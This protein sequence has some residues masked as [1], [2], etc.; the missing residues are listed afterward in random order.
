MPERR[1]TY[2]EPFLGGGALFF[3]Q[4]PASACISDINPHLI[5]TYKVVRD[6]V[7]LLITTLIAHSLR[8]SKEHYLEARR[9]LTLESDPVDLAAL[10]IYLNRTCFNGLYRVNRSGVFNVAFGSYKS[11]AIVQADRLRACSV[12]LQSVHI[13]HC[14]YWEVPLRAGNFYYLDPPYDNTFTG[15]AAAGFDQDEQVLLSEFCHQLD[16]AGCLFMAS[17]SDTPLIRSLYAGFHI[18]TVLARRSISCQR[19]QRG[20]RGELI[21]RNYDNYGAAACQLT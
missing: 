1:A 11:P 3:A 15:Y 17:N 7:E 16:K 14:N 13:H 4:A 21:I 10:F 20:S 2:I 19:Q 8:H 6:Q 18:E 12:A 5:T 9:R